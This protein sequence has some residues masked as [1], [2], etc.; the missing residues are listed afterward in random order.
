MLTEEIV[1]CLPLISSACSGW[2]YACP[3]QVTTLPT[4]IVTNIFLCT[5]LHYSSTTVASALQLFFSFEINI[6]FVLVTGVGSFL[7]SF[8]WNFLKV[9]ISPLCCSRICYSR[10]HRKLGWDSVWKA[11]QKLVYFELSVKGVTY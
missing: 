2:V 9:L 3:Y 7:C 11:N 1:L 6:H 4:L 10:I 5:I 8:H